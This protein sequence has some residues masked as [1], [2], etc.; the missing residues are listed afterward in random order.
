MHLII[1][2]I[3]TGIILIII[4]I[5]IYRHFLITNRQALHFIKLEKAEEIQASLNHLV[6]SL[7]V[8]DFKPALNIDKPEWLT[9][10]ETLFIQYK[11]SV[12]VITELKR[13]TKVKLVGNGLTMITDKAIIVEGVDKTSR[14]RY[15]YKHLGKDFKVLPHLGSVHLST[16]YKK[17]TILF[18][19]PEKELIYISMAIRFIDNIEQ[20]VENDQ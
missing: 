19:L 15:L 10:N 7:K 1:G 17:Q 2:L 18:E 11:S 12:S 16:T 6:Q 8:E 5:R 4:A 14:K 3:A 9:Q 13:S 20:G